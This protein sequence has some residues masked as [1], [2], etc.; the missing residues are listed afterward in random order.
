MHKLEL[1]YYY[2]PCVAHVSLYSLPQ[3]PL[4]QHPAD[5]VE[6]AEQQAR[7]GSVYGPRW[8][9][10]WDILPKVRQSLRIQFTQTPFDS[11]AGLI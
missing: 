4:S 9:Q 5:N 2:T 7:S 6:H 1:A 11:S 8:K 3:H 10:P